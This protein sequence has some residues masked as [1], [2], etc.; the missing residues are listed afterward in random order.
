MANALD[1]PGKV[2]P[3]AGPEGKAETILSDDALWP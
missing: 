1:K 3:Q 2:D